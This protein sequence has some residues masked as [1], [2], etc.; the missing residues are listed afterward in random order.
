MIRD[1]TSCPAT[2]A[3]YSA[4]SSALPEHLGDDIVA[5]TPA[6]HLGLLPGPAAENAAE[7][8]RL[9]TQVLDDHAHW[10]RN[11]HPE[12]PS[13]LTPARRAQL[14][15]AQQDLED[16]VTWLLAQL[17]RSFPFH[18]PRYL[19][20]MQSETTI[21]SLVGGLAGMLFNANNV[22]SESGAVTLQLEIEAC[23]RLLG[24]IGYRPPP[25]PPAEP[26]ADTIAQYLRSL[27]QGFGWCHL[28]SGGTSANV[29]ALWAAR[30]VR[31]SS[32]AIAAAARAVQ[33]SLPVVLP[34][35]N[36]EREIADLSEAQLL[37]LRPGD[38]IDLL[39]RFYQAAL[40]AWGEV[41]AD[42][43][44]SA[45]KRRV[46]DLLAAARRTLPVG[47]FTLR[48]VVLHPGTAHYS[49]KK[50]I[51]VLGLGEASARQVN[52]TLRHRMDVDDLVHKLAEMV[53]TGAEFP[54]AVVAVVGTTE[55]GAVDP[56]HEILSRR[57]EMET[58][59]KHSFWIHA[60]AAWGG[61]LRTMVSPSPRHLLHL[62]TLAIRD[63]NQLDL[64]AM[65][66]EGT[67]HPTEWLAGLKKYLN[68]RGVD[69]AA[70][71]APASRLDTALAEGD[72]SEARAA[73][74]E[75]IDAA[76]HGRP[77]VVAPAKVG[78]A[79][80]RRLV[81][82]MFEGSTY[83]TGDQ[84]ERV[85]R[86]PALKAEFRRSTPIAGLAS[87]DAVLDA[88]DA[89]GQADSVTVDPH[90][91]GYQHYACGAIA[92]RKDAVR[93]HVKQ[94]APYITRL[95][96][97]VVTNQPLWRLEVAV[98]DQTKV[99]RRLES[100]SGFT[101]EGSRPSAPAAALW[102]STTVLPLDTENHGLLVREGYFAARELDTWLRTW[103]EVEDELRPAGAGLFDF[104]PLTWD[105]DAAVVGDSNV[106]IFGVR[107]NRADHDD[108]AGYNALTKKVYQRF[109]ILA[110]GGDHRFSYEQD[111]FL[112]A[113]Q[114]TEPS[115]PEETIAEIG[116]RL[117]LR[118]QSDVYQR[119]G[120][121]V[122]RAT[123][124]NPY[125]RALRERRVD[126]LR[127][128]VVALAAVARKETD[129]KPEASS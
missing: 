1:D 34:G 9:V 4:R 65:F 70:I 35:E 71:A 28:C 67:R 58:N 111:F 41:E 13:L 48:P 18:N 98:D 38:A 42:D 32:L 79:D 7:M 81:T 19:A 101:L 40:A 122:L 15:D 10:R 24:M 108:L 25:T 43:D 82:S 27:E 128:F 91:L 31:L 75:L 8:L 46:D 30:N 74:A 57:K 113:T 88:L 12:D 93:H 116:G 49:V 44:L 26:A 109:A 89:L 92:F 83:L 119:D 36:L 14:A 33:L 6:R 51:D 59:L 104:V 3:A 127:D 56:L 61:Y 78:R 11:L 2:R 117:G 106:V 100:P 99:V 94:A 69:E 125:V 23:N 102:L 68:A 50:A 37:R 118:W 66:G 120:M 87:N 85:V 16:A 63:A 97:A 29:E 124:M 53:E 45:L 72:W 95:N 123:V 86:L 20:H 96:D 64:P 60:D 55:E 77:G 114:F 80:I 129:P 112:S 21:A 47:G 5:Q 121:E 110:E 73:V 76:N 107:D 90:K 126:V 22:T 103:S 115:Y 52:T 17:K 62:E 105:G 39:P 84:L 54:L